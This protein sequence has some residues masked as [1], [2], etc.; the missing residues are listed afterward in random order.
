[1][2]HDSGRVDNLEAYS[3]KL[4]ADGAELA[5]MRFRRTQKLE[6][7]DRSRLSRLVSLF[8]DALTADQAMSGARM[9]PSTDKSVSTLSMVTLALEKIPSASPG[10]ATIQELKEITERVLSGAP[11]TGEYLTKLSAFLRQYNLCQE[12]RIKRTRTGKA[13]GG[14]LW[15]DL[16]RTKSL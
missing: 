9:A 6:E 1:M 8:A 13:S 4:L 5:L 11:P 3:Q 15:P 14:D 16:A 2:M 10:R 12:E 7:L